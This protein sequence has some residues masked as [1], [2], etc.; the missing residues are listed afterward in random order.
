MM[1]KSLI[2][3]GKN[4]KGLVPNNIIR[5]IFESQVELTQLNSTMG[6]LKS[7]VKIYDNA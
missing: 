6:I 1:V 4:L 3:R 5:W 7:V 2:L